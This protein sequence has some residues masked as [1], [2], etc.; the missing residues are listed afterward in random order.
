MTITLL[1]TSGSVKTDLKNFFRSVNV[2]TD[3]K[4]EPITSVMRQNR[5]KIC[6]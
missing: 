4:S 2:I 6:F 5:C 3:V 1:F